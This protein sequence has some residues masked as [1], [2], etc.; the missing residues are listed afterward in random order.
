MLGARKIS[1][2]APDLSFRGIQVRDR[3]NGAQP[4]RSLPIVNPGS[5]LNATSQPHRVMKIIRPDRCTQS[6]LVNCKSDPSASTLG[7]CLQGSTAIYNACSPESVA[8]HLC[9]DQPTTLREYGSIKA[10]RS[11]QSFNEGDAFH[12]CQLD[13]FRRSQCRHRQNLRRFESKVFEL[14]QVT[15]RTEIAGTSEANL[16]IKLQECPIVNVCL[17]KGNLCPYVKLSMREPNPGRAL[18]WED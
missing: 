10:G 6:M 7:L 9:I 11:V 3:V 13:P 2:S 15:V 4:L 8:G 14:S 17:T 12:V 5:V 16:T 18:Q 1:Q